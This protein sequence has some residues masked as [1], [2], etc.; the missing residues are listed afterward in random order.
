[1]KKTL[2]T[3]FILASVS[4]GCSESN[5]VSKNEK[6]SVK[7]KVVSDPKMQAWVGHY[8]AVTPCA[9]CVTRCEGCEGIGIDLKINADQSFIFERTDNNADTKPVVFMG[10]FRFIDPDK[11][12]IELMGV[13]D[14]H[15]FALSEG[16]IEVIDTK[17]ERFFDSD[18]E[19]LLDK[20]T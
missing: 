19:F 16:S 1:M 4:F 17:T 15:K 13:S 3:S 18:D 11:R 14:K 6:S 5:D 10:R 7:I 8:T 20:L 2:L 12:K 9:N